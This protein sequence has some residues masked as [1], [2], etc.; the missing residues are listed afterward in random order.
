[1]A[2]LR[3]EPRHSRNSR[4]ARNGSKD[5]SWISHILWFLLLAV[6]VLAIPL[7]AQSG[8][9]DDRVMLQ[10]FYWESYRHGHQDYPYFGAKK[11]YVIVR[12]QA[13]AIRAARFDLVWLP[14]PS[15]GGGL[16]AGYNPKQYFNLDNSYG[17]FTQHRQA[18]RALLAN[19]VEPIADVVI[20]HRDGT[21]GW[22]DFKNP[23]WG[24]WAITRDDE[25]FSNDNSE[26]KGTPVD[27]R[28]APEEWPAE[29]TQHGGTTYA[30]GDFRDIDHTNEQ[31]RRDI[32]RY[33][34]QLKSMGYRGWR[35]DMVHGYHARWLAHYNRSTTPTFSVGEYDW[36]QQAEQRGWLWYTATT[37]GNLRTSSAV[38][39]FQTQFTLKDN[40][41]SYDAWYGFGNGL[42]IVGDTTDN[43]PWK[44]RAVTFLENHDT[45]YRTKPDGSPQEG[46]ERDSF[47][48]NWEVEQAYAYIL[49]H[50][51]IPTVYWK[52][53]FDWGAELRNKITAIVNARKAAGVHAG[54]ALH[55]QNNARARGVYAAMVEGSRGQ[56]YVRVGGSDN[57]WQ[58]SASNY[59]DYREYAYGAGWK[60]WVKLPGNPPL[61]QAPLKS[62][63]PVPAYRPP[64]TIIVP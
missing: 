32:V 43:H 20:N 41:G 17:T 39:D 46:H 36:N 14:P 34:L 8:F 24:R 51:G 40:K 48:N 53:F 18:L 5:F 57:D 38:F 58:P 61:R 15:F 19:G 62:A 35:Y 54:S 2:E 60:V 56:L 27:Q 37:T 16:S 59:E 49:T 28:G 11:W 26:A 21:N 55:P 13:P 33:L 64:E 42:G 23:D 4:N 47:Q 12:E 29:Y 6:A 25:A 1:M 30:Y 9:D 45:G 7:A 31:V 22:T 3:T 63:L 52:H 50:P 10:G 44:Q